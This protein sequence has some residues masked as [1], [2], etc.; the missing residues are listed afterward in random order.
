VSDSIDV[1]LTHIA[2]SVRDVEASIDFYARYAAMKVV[3]ERPAEGGLGRIVWL[4]D[5]T[6]AFV[7]VLLPSANPDPPL[8]P[9]NHLGFGVASREEVERLAE[10]ARAEGR[11]T[12]PPTDSGP[13]VG[14]WTLLT[15]PDGHTV[16]IAHGQEVGL[17]VF[18]ASA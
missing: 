2:F 9:F 11:L 8:G 10:L 3:H 17:A 5:L 13:P 18:D 7:L 14:Y 16:E 15:D 6:R 1:G 12:L 4:S